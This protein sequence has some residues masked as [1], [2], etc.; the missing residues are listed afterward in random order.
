VWRIP[1]VLCVATAAGACG[2]VQPGV[3]SPDDVALPAR[4]AGWFTGGFDNNEQVWQQGLDETE[5]PVEHGHYTI[6]QLP[7]GRTGAYTFYV[8]RHRGGDELAACRPGLY[9]LH[10]G[11]DGRRL[12]L[13]PYAFKDPPPCFDPYRDKARLDA[14]GELQAEALSTVPG[15]AIHW[16]WNGEV[17]DGRTHKGACPVATGEPDGAHARHRF[18]LSRDQLQV[19]EQAYNAA[20]EQVT[21]NRAGH[22]QHLRRV[23]YYTGWAVLK[24]RGPGAAA[25]DEDYYPILRFRTHDEGGRREILDEQGMPTGYSVHLARLT[26]QETGLAILRL[27]ILQQDREQ[28]LAYSWTEVG[29]PRVGINLRWVQS[30]LTLVATQ[31]NMEEQP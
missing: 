10:A 4:F 8:Q 12:R 28:A 3:P 17:F 2:N 21:G 6:M 5:H 25:D 27:A 29:S 20:G 18:R 9:V 14:L 31:Q 7:A 15:C 22:F 19:I 30:G 26:Y 1:A 24:K 23:R 13:V 16:T 11:S